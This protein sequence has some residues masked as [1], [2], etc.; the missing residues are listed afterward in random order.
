VI[1]SAPTSKGDK[2]VT[3]HKGVG[4][5]LMSVAESIAYSFGCTMGAVIS[6][7]GVRN[8]YAKLGYTLEHKTQYM[9]KEYHAYVNP[10]LFGHTYSFKTINETLQASTIVKQYMSP[11]TVDTIDVDVD[12]AHGTGITIVARHVYTHIQDGEAEGFRFKALNPLTPLTPLNPFMFNLII[13][14]IILN[15]LIMLGV[16]GV[17][18]NMW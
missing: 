10:V 16:A 18:L 1:V 3:Q 11:D 9:I 12:A 14:L 7:V 8:Y 17:F 15:I 5:F 4:A 13:G 6:G 2:A